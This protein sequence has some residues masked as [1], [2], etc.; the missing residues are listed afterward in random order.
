MLQVPCLLQ[1]LLP[2]L[3]G[4]FLPG[5]WQQSLFNSGLTATA[6]P[7]NA[8]IVTMQIIKK[9]AKTFIGANNGNFYFTV[10]LWSIYLLYTSINKY[11]GDIYLYR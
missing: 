4:V 6:F 9:S 5:L 3:H 11:P 8:E 1:S 7:G 2:G 10:Y